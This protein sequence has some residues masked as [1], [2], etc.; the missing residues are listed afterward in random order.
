MDGIF[1]RG[2]GEFETTPFPLLIKSRE[3]YICLFIYLNA[4]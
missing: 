2:A 4:S 1:F 3:Y